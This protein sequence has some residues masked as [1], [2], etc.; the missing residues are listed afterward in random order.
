MD[1]CAFI[2]IHMCIHTH[3]CIHAYTLMHAYIYTCHIDTHTHKLI[4]QTS[5][6]VS[7]IS[8]SNFKLFFSSNFYSDIKSDGRSDWWVGRQTCGL[9]TLEKRLIHS[10]Q[11]GR[12]TAQNDIPWLRAAHRLKPTN[13]WLLQFLTKYIST[14]LATGN[15]MCGLQIR[16]PLSPLLWKMSWRPGFIFSGVRKPCDRTYKGARAVW[17]PNQ[18]A[19]ISR[20]DSIQNAY[21]TEAKTRLSGHSASWG[22][23]HKSEQEPA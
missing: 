17:P 16:G 2:P 5:E 6:S 22:R 1:A 11:E 15:W 14:A 10:L 12:G 4:S 21:E 18:C 19:W 13:C 8:I 23:W 9:G 7:Q 20:D 3:K